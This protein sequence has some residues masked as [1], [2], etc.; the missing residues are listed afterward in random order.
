MLIKTMPVEKIC[1][2]NPKTHQFSP[3]LMHKFNVTTLLFQ[4]RERGLNKQFFLNQAENYTSIDSQ[5][6]II[7]EK[8]FQLVFHLKIIA[9]K[10]AW[11]LYMKK[12]TRNRTGN[13][14]PILQAQ[15]K[16]GILKREKNKMDDSTQMVFGKMRNHAEK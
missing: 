15:D 5:K 16:S 10:T 14:S 4:Q 12:Q 3:K 9:I 7:M 13:I 1:N 2:I 8:P 11:Y 6:K